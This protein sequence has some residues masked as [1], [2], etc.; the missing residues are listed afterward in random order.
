MLCSPVDNYILWFGE[1]IKRNN[2]LLVIFPNISWSEYREASTVMA[3]W[4]LHVASAGFHS[5]TPLLETWASLEPGVIISWMLATHHLVETLRLHDSNKR[6]STWTEGSLFITSAKFWPSS[7]TPMAEMFSKTINYQHG[8]MLFW[9][10]NGYSPWLLF[11]GRNPQD[12]VPSLYI[13]PGSY[14]VSI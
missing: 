12:A 4:L 7:T 5:R 2:C 3:V 1:H 6:P 13:L 14:L 10:I 9:G 8:K 11:S